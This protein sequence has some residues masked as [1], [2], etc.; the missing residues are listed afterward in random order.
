MT[1]IIGVAGAAASSTMP[2]STGSG[3]S[4]AGPCNL[5]TGKVTQR[6][7]SRGMVTAH[8]DCYRLCWLQAQLICSAFGPLCSDA[9]GLIVVVL[10][11]VECHCWN[12][13][14]C[15]CAAYQ[16]GVTPCV[17]QLTLNLCLLTE[18][19][20][21]LPY[22]TQGQCVNQS[23]S[24][25]CRYHGRI[26]PRFTTETGLPHT[27]GMLSR[28]L[29]PWLLELISRSR[30]KTI[31]GISGRSRGVRCCN[32]DLALPPVRQ[33]WIFTDAFFQA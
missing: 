4:S 32:V 26:Q 31:E 8:G 23:N 15:C 19:F 2:F 16:L 10:G 22:W 11:I 17:Y 1:Q 18:V 13:M 33:V 29:L 28:M 5:E 7:W 21:M 14:R 6:H 25:W 3:S 24:G 20:L 12:A 27:M 9:F 30:G